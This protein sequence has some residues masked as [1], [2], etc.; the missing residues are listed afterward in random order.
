MAPT[1]PFAHLTSQHQMSQLRLHRR[2]G[3]DIITRIDI[4][5]FSQPLILKD[6]KKIQNWNQGVRAQLIIEAE[7]L[8]ELGFSLS[9]Q[10]G[11]PQ[12]MTPMRSEVAQPIHQR[13]PLIWPI[14]PDGCVEYI[15]PLAQAVD[16]WGLETPPGNARFSTVST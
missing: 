6:G 9:S 4:A 12:S 11:S 1:K 5:G 8:R 15:P 16:R 2:P 13:F 7:R 3:T 14:S 10:H